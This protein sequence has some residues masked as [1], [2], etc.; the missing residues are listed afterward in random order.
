MKFI[1]NA[2]VNKS[3]IYRWTDVLKNIEK[4]LDGFCN[5]FLHPRSESPL[6]V[7]APINAEPTALIPSNA[8]VIPAVT[9]IANALRVLAIIAIVNDT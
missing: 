3:L 5:G 8:A 2:F 6:Q 4:S 1:D 9:I 7:V